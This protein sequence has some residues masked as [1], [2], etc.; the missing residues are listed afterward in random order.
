MF[1]LDTK[2]ISHPWAHGIDGVTYCRDI[3]DIHDQLIALGQMGQIGRQ[4]T[5]IAA[6]LGIDADPTAIGLR[7]LNLLEEINATL[8]QLARSW[9]KIRESGDPKVSPAVDALRACP[10]DHVTCPGFKSLA[11]SWGGEISRMRNGCG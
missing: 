8:R 1:V 10:T 9:E 5:R 2:K 4:R 11:C 7:I 3:A 6:A